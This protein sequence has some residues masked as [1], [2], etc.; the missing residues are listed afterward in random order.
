MLSYPQGIAHAAEHTTWKE[1]SIPCT[2]PRF[3]VRRQTTCR[4]HAVNVRMMEQVLAPGMKDTEKAN[5]RSQVFR[6]GGNLQESCGAGSKQKC[7]N[8]FL[9]MKRQ[10]RKCVRN[11][12][13]QMDV[14][15]GQ[16]FLLAGRQ[17][18]FPGIVQT[19]RAMAVAAAVIRDGY[20]MTTS[21]T[22]VPVSS[23]R[24]RPA[25]PDGRK[26]FEVQYCQPGPMF[27][28]EAFTCRANDVRHL[29]GWPHHWGCFLPERFTSATSDTAIVSSGFG[30][31]FMWRWDKCK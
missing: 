24:R 3:F 8:Q 16:E 23:K 6:I 29:E 31:A 12:K 25:T 19:L 17:P 15:N 9:V 2:C 5:L 27:L 28:D 1:E 30:Q 10:R 14:R 13:N 20:D 26:H 4:N 7:V 18:L 22:T 21:S 11:R